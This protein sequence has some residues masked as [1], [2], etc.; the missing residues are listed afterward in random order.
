MINCMQLGT[1]ER[2]IMEELQLAVG[3]EAMLV[4]GG[5]VGM[6]RMITRRPRPL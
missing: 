3:M 1:E 2:E 6:I 4:Q 5:M